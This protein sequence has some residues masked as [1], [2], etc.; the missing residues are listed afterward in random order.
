MTSDD[1]KPL[2][3][4]QTLAIM[5]VESKNELVKSQIMERMF[6][7]LALQGHPTRNQQLEAANTTKI[8]VLKITLK[9][10]EVMHNEAVDAE[11]KKSDT[12]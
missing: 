3:E 5:I 10:L 9:E 11:G 8:N 7:R 4:R 2:T 1:L 6:R 12:T